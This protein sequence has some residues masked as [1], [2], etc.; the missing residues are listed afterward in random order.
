MITGRQY[1]RAHQG[2][3]SLILLSPAEFAALLSTGKIALPARHAEHFARVL[4]RAGSWAAIVGNGLNRLCEADIVQGEIRLKPEGDRSA[5]E[6]SGSHQVVIAQAWIKPKALSLV[7]QKCAELG[8]AEIL[9]FDCEYS[10]PHSEK[11]QR[12]DAIL[13]NACMQAYNPVKPVVRFVESIAALKNAQMPAFFGDP[14][15][16]LWL[17]PARGSSMFICG[18]EGGF[19]LAEVQTLRGFASGV[20]ISENVLRAETAAIIA[21]GIL[22][23]GK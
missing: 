14:T 2:D 12:I 20:L 17:T 11:P 16:S 9:L 19:S 7:L 23:L 1:L 22:C 15:S 5:T 3:H 8:A 4:R 10:A 18:P 6:F 21:A 13:E